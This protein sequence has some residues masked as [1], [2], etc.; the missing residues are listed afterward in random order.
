MISCTCAKS[1]GL[2]RR[3]FRPCEDILTTLGMMFRGAG[4]KNYS[5]E[6]LH[7]THNMKKV[8]NDNVWAVD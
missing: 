1:P 7:F 3:R 5:T 6:I 2:Y 4:S 8:W